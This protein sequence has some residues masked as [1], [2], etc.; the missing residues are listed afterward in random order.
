M[1]NAALLKAIIENAIDGIVV[2]DYRGR[3]VSVNPSACALFGYSENELC[4]NNV[5]MLIPPPDKDIHDEYIKQYTQTRQAHVIGIGR[6]VIALKK[7]GSVFPA[8][9]AVSEAKLNGKNIFV[10]II[11][12]ISSEKAAQQKL[13]QYNTELESVVKERTGFLKNIVSELEKAKEEVN[14]SLMKEKEVNLL[15]TRFVSMASHEF[16]TPLSTIQ[17]SASLIEHYYDRL[18]KGKIF[19]HLDKIKSAVVNLTSILNDFLSVE[20]I[21]AGKISPVYIEF[22]LK[23]FCKEIIEAMKMQT[24]QGQRINYKHIGKTS[25]I[26]L[27]S[28]LLQHCLVNLISNAIKYSHE[29]GM[30]ELKTEI[31]AE[32]CRIEVK[33]QGI[34]IPKEDQVH[35][36]EVFFRASN[37]NDIEGTGLGLNIVKRY[38]EL[39]SG[40]IDFESDTTTGSIFTLTFPIKAG[41]MRFPD[42]N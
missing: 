29:G 9:L 39:M 7:D 28:N 5:N 17:L 19:R 22:E 30:I 11:H 23:E 18:N 2:I 33:D 12:D 14:I 24:K 34:S 3:M 26:T 6:V 8:R 35:L 38:T 27:D 15:K 16:R 20:R 42:F 13:Q 4:G 31:G 21:E 1:H 25:R 40:R 32:K 36:F 10:G 37:T 41:N